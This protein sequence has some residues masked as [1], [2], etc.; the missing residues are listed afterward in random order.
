MPEHPKD[1]RDLCR[2]IIVEHDTAK[3]L[4]LVIELNRLL[5]QKRPAETSEQNPQTEEDEAV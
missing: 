1:W 2:A 3:L 4:E 5:E